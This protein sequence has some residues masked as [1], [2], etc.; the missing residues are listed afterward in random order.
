MNYIDEYITLED[1]KYIV[2]REFDKLDYKFGEFNTLSDAIEFRNKIDIDGWPLKKDTP[3]YN[4]NN[5]KHIPYYIKKFIDEEIIYQKRQV[6]DNDPSILYIYRKF[7]D[8]LKED[9]NVPIKTFK[10]YF[11]RYTNKKLI[12]R[13]IFN[14]TSKYNISFKDEL[15]KS[16]NI[17]KNNS[18]INS[19]NSISKS[20]TIIKVIH[21]RNNLE[22]RI[23]DFIDKKI[24]ILNRKAN[25]N[26]PI[27]ED[28]H[29][30]FNNYLKTFNESTKKNTFSNY[31]STI[32]KKN[33]KTDQIVINGKTHY[34][35]SLSNQTK[36][37][38]EKSS[39]KNMNISSKI[40][41]NEINDIIIVSI[42]GKCKYE[43]FESLLNN[44]KK[45][46][47]KIY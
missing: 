35:V 34:N 12:K 30:E 18:I 8:Y 9:I 25:E 24:N 23:S 29:S 31:F 1:S 21:G 33:K 40:N 38:K 47:I 5:K 17:S 16:N 41:I 27:I 42:D 45:F 28:I 36:T 4:S 15:N 44:L 20:N 11:P 10:Y 2:H 37:I 19:S 3:L 26:D 39:E 43:K 46:I 7:K 22:P 13:E 32:L 14:N 6:Q